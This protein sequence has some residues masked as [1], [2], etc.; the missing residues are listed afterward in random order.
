MVDQRVI[1]EM[2]HDL[3]TF[4]MWS[5]GEYY[6]LFIEP[7]GCVAVAYGQLADRT[8]NIRRGI[9][10]LENALAEKQSDFS[11]DELMEAVEVLEDKIQQL[12]EEGFRLGSGWSDD[13][14]YR[15]YVESAVALRVA[16]GKLCR[17]IKTQATEPR[18]VEEKSPEDELRD[19]LSE[20]CG[21][22]VI[23]YDADFFGRGDY[24]GRA[25]YTDS[26]GYL[27]RI[28]VRG[29]SWLD[30][31]QSIREEVADIQVEAV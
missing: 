31:A 6:R 22:W 13:P 27:S 30:V 9:E 14:L 8:A 16:A 23:S 28:R 26:N 17:A 20:N 5:R 11:V 2:K 3:D 21:W 1:A 29:G 19:W 25:G 4:E 12:A 10:E 24:V 7:P 15:G 18:V